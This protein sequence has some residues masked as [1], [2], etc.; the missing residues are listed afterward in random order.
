MVHNSEDHKEK[1][2]SKVKETGNEVEE[3]K[4]TK[5]QKKRENDHEIQIQNLEKEEV[6]NPDD[7]QEI[8]KKWLKNRKRK[9]KL[10]RMN[11]WM[12]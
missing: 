7:L 3:V 9:L 10:V 12:E 6:L 11:S 5:N 4:I 8:K 2:K 1:D